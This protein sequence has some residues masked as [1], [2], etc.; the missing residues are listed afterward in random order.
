M[1]LN[2]KGFPRSLAG[3]DL[4]GKVGN[5]SKDIQRFQHSSLAGKAVIGVSSSALVKAPSGLATASVTA[6]GTGYVVG[7]IVKLSGGTGTFGASVKVT[8]VSSGA[9]TGVSIYEP[10]VYSAVPTAPFSSTGGTGSGA[11][12]GGTFTAAAATSVSDKLSVGRNDTGFDYLGYDPGDVTAGYKGNSVQNGTQM[13]I[14]FDCDAPRI[15][16]RLVG[17]N[18]QYDLYADG[19]RVS[20]TSVATDSSGGAYIYTI[21]WNG[22]SKPRRY[23]LC[24]INSAFGG[25]YISNIYSVFPPVGFR[26]PLAWQMGDSYTVGV[27]ASQASYNDFRVMCDLLGFEGIADGISGAGWSSN[28]AGRVPDWRVRNKLGVLTRKADYVFLAMGYN[29]NAADLTV[30]TQ[31]FEDAVAA[32]KEVA[33][34][35]RVFVIGAA[36]PKGD[37]AGLD[38]VRAAI[39]ASCDKLKL[40]YID[41]RNIVNAANSAIYTGGDNIHPTNSGHIFRGTMMARLVSAKM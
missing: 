21:D 16:F 19:N 32:V 26:K 11:T 9:I 8:T 30:V 37:T 7:D 29:D 17:L 6:G 24:G 14:Q 34:K 23:R 31:Q 1:A 27:G 12:F 36:T 2:G 18:S 35:A 5:V 13:C 15:D 40:D 22:E 3:V 20:A 25:L 28:Q 10:G 41:M 38:G 39:M 33:P 4:T